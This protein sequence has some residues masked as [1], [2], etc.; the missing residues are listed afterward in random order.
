VATTRNQLS[1]CWS[2]LKENE[3]DRDKKKRH[4]YSERRP[5]FGPAL[6]NQQVGLEQLRVNPTLA[7][8]LHYHRHSIMADAS[9]FTNHLYV[10]NIIFGTYII[11]LT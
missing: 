7:W 8:T 9:F 2:L 5:H 1:V 3:R 4:P 6:G 10:T 11:F